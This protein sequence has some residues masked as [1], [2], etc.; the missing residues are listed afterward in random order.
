[1]STDYSFVKLS[2]KAEELR[3]KL[4]DFVNEECIP[5]E[6]LLEA[7]L[8]DA[9]KGTAGRFAK[10]PPILD[11]LA[12]KARSLGLWN[13]FL[14]HEY[15]LPSPGLT[16][17]EYAV[18][19]EIL[20]RSQ[21][22][23]PVV[24]NC[25]APD[26]GNMELLAKYGTEAQK[27]KWLKPLMNGEIRSAFVMTEPDQA[28]SDATNVSTRIDKDGKGNYV[29]NGRKWWITNGHN[30]RTK[31]YILI[32][33]T[34]PDNASR[35]RQQSIVLIPRDTPGITVVQ[36][37]T[38]LGEDDAPI[39]HCELKLEN[40]TIPM[41]NVILGEG[42]GFEVM[43]GRMGPGRIHHCMRA[44]GQAERALDKLI[45]EATDEKKR[46]FGKTKASHQTVLFAIGECR[47]EIEQARLLVL[48]AAAKID[49]VGTK[50]ALKEI[51]MAK[52][53]VPNV[54]GRVLDRA[55]QVSGA[56]GLSDA[57]ELASMFSNYRTLRYVD[58]PDAVHWE[59]VSK[60]E[61]RRADELRKLYDG[62]H[63]R[64]KELMARARL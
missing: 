26:T 50:A 16:N 3:R 38:V 1:M 40:V 23:A 18:L 44:I 35:H 22:V 56:A 14:G 4:I 17:L 55:M 46:P 33:K 12:A 47:M 58:G 64:S 32:G 49:A 8:G 48:N 5:A 37:L 51:G 43:Q 7:Q 29:I 9:K 19:C 60:T 13:L 54:L 21:N 39:G 53:I 11:E 28:S 20:G 27:E 6:H 41:S 62:Y 34:D 42:R 61:L 30:P 57:H 63:K 2:P 15:G 45:L 10:W 25:N 52:V 59:Q 36:D 24:T 31:L